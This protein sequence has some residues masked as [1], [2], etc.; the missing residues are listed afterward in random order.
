MADRMSEDELYAILA[1][2]WPFEVEDAS[3]LWAAENVR[4]ARTALATLREENRKLK[5]RLAMFEA[6][7]AQFIASV[8]EVQ[9][10]LA[11]PSMH[12]RSDG[13]VEWESRYWRSQDECSMTRG[14][15]KKKCAEN[16]ELRNRL[17]EPT[18]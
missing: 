9:S 2:N 5:S 16:E 8:S 18:Q 15:L 17:A 3:L 14:E 6:V 7:D 4:T 11:P 1:G 10:R 12:L 13:P